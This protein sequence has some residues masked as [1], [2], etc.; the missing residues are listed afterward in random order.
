VKGERVSKAITL[1]GRD[2]QFK[3]GLSGLLDEMKNQ[4][5]GKMHA[6]TTLDDAFESMGLIHTIFDNTPRLLPLRE[7]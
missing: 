6:L 4:L 5:D 7:M 1:A 3:P 2:L